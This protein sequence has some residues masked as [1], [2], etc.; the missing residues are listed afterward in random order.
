MHTFH[1]FHRFSPIQIWIKAFYLQ[2]A[3]LPCPAL[4][5]LTEYSHC[6]LSFTYTWILAG[7]SL[8]ALSCFCGFFIHPCSYNSR[9]FLFLAFIFPMFVQRFVRTWATFTAHYYYSLFA[10]SLHLSFHATSLSFHVPVLYLCSLD[11]KSYKR[12]PW[13]SQNFLFCFWF[14]H[15]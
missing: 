10:Y 12:H 8:F 13:A 7:C 5:I 15:A 3:L 2:E 9:K 6:M 1:Y 4:I 11:T 14:H